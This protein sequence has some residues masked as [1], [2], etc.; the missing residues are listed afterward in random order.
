[1]TSNITRF[2]LRPRA[3]YDKIKR[4]MVRV[5][6]NFQ[7]GGIARRCRAPEETVPLRSHRSEFR[8][9]S[10]AGQP[11]GVPAFSARDKTC[12][13]GLSARSFLK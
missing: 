10:P 12:R 11:R 8:D 1:M 3:Q 13:A 5:S 4:F 2:I 7:N 9:V 6:K